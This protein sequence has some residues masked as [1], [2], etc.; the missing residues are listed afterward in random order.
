MLG[1]TTRPRSSCARA[2]PPTSTSASPPRA[3]AA[4]SWGQLPPSSTSQHIIAPKAV[5]LEPGVCQNRDPVFGK[6]SNYKEVTAV[7]RSQANRGTKPTRSWLHFKITI[8]TIVVSHSL[9]NYPRG[10][11]PNVFF[12]F[13]LL[14]SSS[15]SNNFYPWHYFPE[16]SSGRSNGFQ[17]NLIQT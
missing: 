6:S 3:T 14:L 10:P 2:A 16:N 11:P 1:E 15:L 4:T 12:H 9:R 8:L 13:T 5:A 7:C 17:Q